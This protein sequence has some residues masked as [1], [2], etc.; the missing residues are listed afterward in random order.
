[1]HTYTQETF[2]RLK[3]IEGHLLV[4][5]AFL[6]SKKEKHQ[7]LSIWNAGLQCR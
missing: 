7:S 4:I 1:M 5:L 6:K 3:Y 2:R